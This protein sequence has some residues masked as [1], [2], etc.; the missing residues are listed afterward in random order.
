[1]Y[2]VAVSTLH[3]TLINIEVETGT[4]TKAFKQQCMDMCPFHI[5]PLSV[6]ADLAAVMV[7]AGDNQNRRIRRQDGVRVVYWNGT[8]LD[9][10]QSL[11]SQVTL[12]HNL[13]LFKLVFMKQY[14]FS[15]REYEMMD[16][17]ADFGQRTSGYHVRGRH[18]TP[19]VVM[20][21]WGGQDRPNAILGVMYQHKATEDACRMK[22]RGVDIRQFHNDCPV[23][24]FDFGAQ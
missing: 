13:F 16:D 9:D 17:F 1:M 2:N 12:G 18:G 14:N 20:P 24:S 3:G 15:D 19:L 4:L 22:E 11:G 5:T 7:S 23:F 8:F 21:V 6:N 10:E